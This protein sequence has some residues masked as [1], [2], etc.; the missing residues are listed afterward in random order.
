VKRLGDRLRVYARRDKHE[1]SVLERRRILA[2]LSTLTLAKEAGISRNSV[3]RLERNH[4]SQAIRP[5]TALKIVKA[6]SNRLEMLGERA[7]TFEDLFE[8]RGDS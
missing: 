4:R 6:L 1:T 2:G 7:C 5:D 3:W 8:L